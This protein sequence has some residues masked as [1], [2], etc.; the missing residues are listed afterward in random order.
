M[1]DNTR[2]KRKLYA[3]DSVRHT[4]SAAVAEQVDGYGRF[5]ELIFR[6]LTL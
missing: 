1:D 5:N 2:D 4:Y 3:A 6:L